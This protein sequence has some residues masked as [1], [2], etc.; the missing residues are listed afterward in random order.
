MEST[1]DEGPDTL[2]KRRR[3]A[4]DLHLVKTNQFDALFA[5]YLPVIKVTCAMQGLYDGEAIEVA[6]VVMMRM[7]NEFRSGK[8]FTDVSIYGSI[9]YKT[10]WEAQG[11]RAKRHRPFRGDDELM[12]PADLAGLSDLA[13][14]DD[15]SDFVVDDYGYL[16][17]ALE[18]LSD[19]QRRVLEL[20]Y[21]EDLSVSEV[22]EYLGATPNAVSQTKFQALKKLAAILGA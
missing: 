12:P 3:Q 8:D 2:E 19:K 21:L 14:E 16:Y 6:G 22:A 1:N 9:L 15:Y 17:A 5:D 7:Y 20:F 18:C 13:H 10:R 4:R 11:V